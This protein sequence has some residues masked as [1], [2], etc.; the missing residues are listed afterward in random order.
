MFF[1][2]KIEKLSQ[3]IDQQKVKTKRRLWE[4]KNIATVLGVAKET[5]RK[6]FAKESLIE[7][8]S[9]FKDWKNNPKDAG[10]HNKKRFRF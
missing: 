5:K 2:R 10:K 1:K 3:E 6:E 8:E 9:R 7:A 4:L